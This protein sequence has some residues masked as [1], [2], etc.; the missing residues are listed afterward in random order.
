MHI[1][2]VFR[3]IA[4]LLLIVSFFMIFP[5]LFALYYHEEWTISAFLIP[6]AI[7]LVFSLAI[8]AVQL[9]AFHVR[10][11]LAFLVVS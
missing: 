7:I 10:P 1:G 11:I 4:I 2:L 8:Y 9:L 5:I 3:V 6:I